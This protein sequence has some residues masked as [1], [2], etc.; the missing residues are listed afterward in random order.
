MYFMFLV[1]MH[2]LFY[3][4]TIHRVPYI[5]AKVDLE[6]WICRTELLAE[7]LHFSFLVV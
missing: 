2:L 4:P 6:A 7:F 1:F 3:I 5:Q